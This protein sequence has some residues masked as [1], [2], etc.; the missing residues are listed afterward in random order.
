MKHQIFSRLKLGIFSSILSALAVL[1]LVVYMLSDNGGSLFSS[2]KPAFQFSPYLDLNLAVEGGLPLANTFFSAHAK[3]IINI[4]ATESLKGLKALTLAFA[5][6]ECG[7]EHWGGLNAQNV[8]T[9]NVL[10]LQQ[11]NLGYM[12]STGGSDG[13]FTCNST[14]GMDAFIG[15]YQSTHLLGFDF[16]IE[17]NQTEAVIQT[18][19]RQVGGAMKRYPNLRFSFT[20]AALAS[21]DSS[22][23]NQT[24]QWVMKAIAD[25]GL[26]Y[27]FIN[28]M[29]MNYGRAEPGNCVVRSGQ[30]DMA[31]SAI[32]AVNNLSRKYHIPLERIEVTPM[33]GL[34]DVATNIFSLEDA[35]KL[36]AFARTFGLGGLH[37]WSLN[38]DT[39]CAKVSAGLSASCHSLPNTAKLAFTETFAK[40]GELPKK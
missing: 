15:R 10:A 4:P 33:I 16:N 29:V 28:L 11:A 37:F 17:A 26:K 38:R 30:C 13:D 22:S 3:S 12:I 40:L 25:E 9:A 31:A 7:K 1:G 5:T 24:G 14:E 27:F 21:N 39:P 34:N 2:P 19:V 20:L 18:L 36:Q 23:L 8:A 32:R 35:Q 6:G